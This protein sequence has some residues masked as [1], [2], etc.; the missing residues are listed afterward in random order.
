MQHALVKRMMEKGREE[1]PSAGEIRV[2]G[3]IPDQKPED[4][5][6]REPKYIPYIKR[7]IA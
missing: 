6:I 3:L 5:D 1:T 7:R 2:L 4:V